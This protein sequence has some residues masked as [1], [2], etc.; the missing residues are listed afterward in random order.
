[1]QALQITEHT[2]SPRVKKQATEWRARWCIQPHFLS[3]KE[4]HK[5]RNRKI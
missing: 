3:W 4:R 5:W 2:I 1:M